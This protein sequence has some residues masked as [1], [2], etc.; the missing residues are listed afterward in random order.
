MEAHVVNARLA[1]MRR[2][3]KIGGG[4]YIENLSYYN[5]DCFTLLK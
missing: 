3:V 1:L 4:T 5:A 2:L